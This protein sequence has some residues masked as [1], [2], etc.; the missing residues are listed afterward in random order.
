[1]N[2]RKSK[3]EYRQ[4]GSRAGNGGGKSCDSCNLTRRV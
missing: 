4:V 2:N 1:M 3:L